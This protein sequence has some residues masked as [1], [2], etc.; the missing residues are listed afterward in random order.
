MQGLNILGEAASKIAP[1]AGAGAELAA[2]AGFDV[3]KDAARDYLK[4]TQQ[5]KQPSQQQS[6]RQ[7]QKE[8]NKMFMASLPKQPTTIIHQNPSAELQ[9][10][11]SM[12]NPKVVY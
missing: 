7:Q 9:T 10:V 6:L 2:A 8:Y 3:A 12:L 5:P 11:Y 4:D 1:I